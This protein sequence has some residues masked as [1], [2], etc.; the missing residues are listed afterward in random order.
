[1]TDFQVIGIFFF[2]AFEMNALT[3][4]NYHPSLHSMIHRFW[5]MIES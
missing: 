4:T 5:T 3:R 2:L 1:M